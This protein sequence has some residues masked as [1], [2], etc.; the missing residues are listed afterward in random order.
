[1]A[2][3]PLVE[4][5]GQDPHHGEPADQQAR[6]DHLLPG[7]QDQVRTSGRRQEEKVKPFDQETFLILFVE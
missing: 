2:H 1:M 5:A 3:L 7:R 4:E 6:A